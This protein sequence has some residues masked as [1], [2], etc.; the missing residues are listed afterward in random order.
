MSAHEIYDLVDGIALVIAGW[1]PGHGSYYV[2]IYEDGDAWPCPSIEL[3]DDATPITEPEWVLDILDGYATAPE[4][5]VE[6]LRADAE[7]EGVSDMQAMLAVAQPLSAAY[8]LSE[9][10]VPF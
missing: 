8:Q 3:G 2:H 5:F 4:G 6:T 7:K 1:D 9:T 10:E